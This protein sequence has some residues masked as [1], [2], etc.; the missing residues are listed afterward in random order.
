MRIGF[1][2]ERPTQFEAPFFRY[3]A[4]DGD[5]RLR[6]LFTGAEPGGEVYDPELGRPVSWGFDLLEGYE[7]AAA[8]A[9]GAGRWL[10][11]EIRDQGLDLL[12]VNGYTRRPYL[13]ATAL[14]RRAGLPV[15]LRLDT[16]REGG[17]RERL[18]RRL[19]AAVLA[20][21]YDLFLATGTLALEYVRWCGV[22]E[23]RT[24][25]F[26]YAVDVAR[27]RDASQIGPE[28][29]A[30]L[31]ARWGVPPEA[32]V[33]L[34]VAKLHPREA[35][36][37]VLRA[38]LH[39]PDP[40]L[41]V[42]VAGDGPSRPDLEHAA[43]DLPRVVWLGYVPYPELPALYGA[44]D[45]FV[46]PAREERWGVSVA[47]ALACGLP[48]VTSSR[49]GA[50][51][52]LV[53]EGENGFTYEAGDGE[54]LARRLTQALELD[55]VAVAATSDEIL[56]RWDYAASWHGLLAAAGRTLERRRGGRGALA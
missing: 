20:R 31:R 34:S 5:N 18:R 7:H 38:A 15:A 39:L 13:L 3:T 30:S 48:V 1:L 52:D 2:V 42:L 19:A 25:L 36:W 21:A 53:W 23:E 28:R 49:V 41:W 50:A 14:A 26:P 45:V 11:H 37:D 51:R 29:R 16:V 4:A 12:I 43:R 33:V 47:E 35:P 22:P 32:R 40:D 54:G 8:P 46:H 10:A 24:G 44:A 6:V 17:P 9:A 27:F 55:P 56:A